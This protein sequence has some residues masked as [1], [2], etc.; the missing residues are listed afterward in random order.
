[1]AELPLAR[2]LTLHTP[3]L[4]TEKDIFVRSIEGRDAI[5]ELFSYE[6]ILYAKSGELD[7]SK[8][9][10]Q[11]MCVGLQQPRG[12]H[13]GG[14]ERERFFHGY[15]ASLASLGSEEGWH[16]YRA[17]LRPHFWRLTRSVNCRVYEGDTVPDIVESILRQLGISFDSHYTEPRDYLPWEYCVQY[18]ESD[19]AFIARLLEHEGIHYSFKHEKGSHTLLLSDSNPGTKDAIQ[20]YDSVDF[21]QGRN[22]P[23]RRDESAWNW[24]RAQHVLSDRTTAKDYDF[25]KPN[26][27][28]AR[29]SSSEINRAHDDAR[30]YE[31]YDYLETFVQ[32]TG[33]PS[34]AAERYARIRTTE[35]HTRYEVA[36]F[37]TDARGLS[38]GYPFKFKNGPSTHSNKGFLVVSTH[39][40]AEVDVHGSS[41]TS[42]EGNVYHCTVEAIDLNN[43]YRPARVTP[44]P[45]IPGP[46]SAVVAG[47]KGVKDI[48]TDQWGRVLVKFHWF[49]PPGEKD[50]DLSCWL[51]VSQ[52][53]AGNGWGSMF[54][55]HIGQEVI[56]SFYDGDPDRPVVTGRVYN[57]NNKPPLTLPTNAEKSIIRDHFG[58]QIIFDGTKGAE[59]VVF[60][61]PNHSSI[62]ML[63]RSKKQFTESDEETRTLNSRSYTLG[64]SE[65]Y[66]FGNSLTVTRGMT[67]NFSAG[68]SYGLTLGAAVTGSLSSVLEFKGG[69]TT[70]FCMSASTSWLYSRDFKATKGEYARISED[71]IQ[72]SSEKGVYISGGSDDHSLFTAT[73][74]ALTL[75]YDKSSKNRKGII[76]SADASAKAT[77]LFCAATAGTLA[78]ASTWSYLKPTHDDETI[79]KGP[80]GNPKKTIE[81][82]LDAFKS[83]SAGDVGIGLSALTSLA[84]AISTAHFNI[85][86]PDHPA[87]TA[88]I[89]LKHESIELFAAKEKKEVRISLAKETGINIS[90]K[91]AIVVVSETGL[92]L[93]SKDKMLISAKATIDVKGKFKHKNI[94]VE[95]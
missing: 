75:S 20:G 27:D 48:H 51:R 59:H 40:R 82:D 91:K 80:N 13:G 8:V 4:G 18:R 85:P 84:G 62:M 64:E 61:S 16:I 46:Q 47:P 22:V 15:V 79:G 70:S 1:M 30:N 34:D 26:E 68:M 45:R 5:S 63:G 54:V 3:V 73:D 77:A 25:T 94:T 38:A 81:A 36:N 57:G 92:K 86:E 24:T 33:Y 56:V 41:S 9:L 2:Q 93:E 28:L 37:D 49:R 23:N 65:S 78:H 11:E 89:T 90:A 50:K 87:P 55:P 21:V 88:K 74:D 31:V 67:T 32:Q 52:N 7:F 95:P 83:L 43:P 6:V 58:N 14:A 44:K 19:F 42:A 66:T 29:T 69:I 17:E 76:G 12:L 39:L 71:Q 35:L 53:S 72:M 60:Q 10:G